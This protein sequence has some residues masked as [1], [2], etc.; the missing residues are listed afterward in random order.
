MDPKFVDNYVMTSM[1]DHDYSPFQ[2]S[3]NRAKHDELEALSNAGGQASY[4]EQKSDGDGAGDGGGGRGLNGVSESRIHAAENVWQGR[5][6][7]AEGDATG[8]GSGGTAEK[9]K[10]HLKQNVE[11]AKALDQRRAEEKDQQQEEE[12]ARHKADAIKSHVTAMHE[13][14]KDSSEEQHSEPQAHKSDPQKEKEQ[15]DGDV[16]A[17]TAPHSLHIATPEELIHDS[18][19]KTS[20]SKPFSKKC[21]FP[22]VPSR[23]TFH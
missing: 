2:K 4:P 16:N 11:E 9:I 14:I 19:G 13:R 7:F 17:Q 20:L 21:F 3:G 18:E 5:R 22:C 6:L 8:G 12:K 10:Q 1:F 23:R 15:E